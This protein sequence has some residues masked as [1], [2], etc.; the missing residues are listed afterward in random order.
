MV[1]MSYFCAQNVWHQI[2]SFLPMTQPSKMP[3]QYTSDIYIRELMQTHRIRGLVP[4]YCP[5]VRYPSQALGVR[6]KQQEDSLGELG[7]KVSH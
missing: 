6:R 3:I 2:H 4:Q 5:Y 1:G 7:A